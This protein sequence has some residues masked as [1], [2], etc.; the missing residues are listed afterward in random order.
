MA[1]TDEYQ[2]GCHQENQSKQ[3]ARGSIPSFG[4]TDG[5]RAPGI[6]QPEGWGSFTPAY[7]WTTRPRNSLTGRLGLLHSSLQDHNWAHGTIP[8]LPIGGSR[9][10][11]RTLLV[12]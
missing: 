8:K 5:R 9:N 6:P 3:S 11:R 12:G 1:S 2:N 7:R 10:T 4:C